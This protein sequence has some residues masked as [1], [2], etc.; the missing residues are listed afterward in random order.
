MISVMQ[1][2]K[3]S[4][5]TLATL[6]GLVL[7]LWSAPAATVALPAAATN[8]SAA[9]RKYS[10]PPDPRAHLDLA[11]G[12]RPEFWSVAAADTIM[13]RWPDFT[14]AYDNGW[15]YV[16]G[17]TLHG[18]ELLYRAT[19]D[20]KY[21]DYIQRYVDR[22]VDA[23][24]DFRAVVNARG[25]TNRPSF[26]SL[27]N[28]MPG[29][30]VI[31]LYEVT[32]ELRYKKAAETIRHALDD[33]PRNHDGGLWHNRRMNGQMWIDGIFMGQ[34]FLMR[35]GRSIGD[36]AACWDEVT[37]QIC[38]YA[39]RAERGHS[40][41]YLHGYFEAGHGGTVPGW[42]DQQTGLAPEVWSEGLGWYAL[43]LAEALSDLPREHPRRAEVEDVFRRLAAG[44][45][46]TQDPQSGRWFQVV[47]KG[48]RPDNWTDNSGS[49]MF[50]YALA[51]GIGLG[52]LD[53]NEYEPVL[54][55]GYAGI[56]AN[57]R[58]NERG[59]VDIYSACEALGIQSSYERY[60]KYP[61]SIN[62]R[63]AVAGFL[64]ATTLVEKPQ[65]EA[66]KTQ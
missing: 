61:R 38:L 66:R 4:A 17:Y 22:F 60:I 59:L 8:N 11:P 14:Q 3:T 58:I 27:D 35:Y 39:G 28:L 33:F 52:L 18:F 2:F 42:A 63:E 6:M 57:A 54:L 50:T 24:G 23:G 15:T 37:K 16:N 19:G 12:G 55:R 30:E 32:Q 62:A 64:W 36:S 47:D 5:V 44:L 43:V 25:Q 48:D 56:T 65:L 40:G 31:L 7:P 29:S 9:P 51:K 41:L 21:F 49:A 46:R 26:N 45:K 13:A 10:S 20:R 1:S 34:M 53:R